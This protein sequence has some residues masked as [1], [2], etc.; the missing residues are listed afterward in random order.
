MSKGRMS[1]KDINELQEAFSYFDRDR[2]GYISSAELPNVMRAIGM[3]PSEA[4]I[5]KLMQSTKSSKLSFNDLLSAVQQA[6]FE[7]KVDEAS[8]REAFKMF[9]LYGNGMVNLVQMRTSLQSLGE[10]LRDE[11]I[12]EL[13]READIDA[14]GN[15]QYE[16]LVRILCRS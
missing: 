5:A 8:M 11:E 16:E 13:I 9:D 4:D 14:D 12:D 2:K 1:Q 7:N 10:K 6:G 3:Y 15:V